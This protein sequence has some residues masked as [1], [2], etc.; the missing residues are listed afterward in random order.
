VS[1]FEKHDHWREKSLLVFGVSDVSRGTHLELYAS[2]S[3][4]AIARQVFSGKEGRIANCDLFLYRRLLMWPDSD[5]TSLS[6]VDDVL[7]ELRGKRWLFRG[8]SKQHRNLV[9]SI[10]RELQNKP[11]LQKLACERRSIDLFRSTARF[12]A[13]SGEQEA[14]QNDLTALMV[15]R[16]YGVPTRLLDWSLSPF[17][18]AYFAVSDLDDED[19][20][21]WCFDEP[22][23]EEIGRQQWAKWPE[24]TVSGDGRSFLADLTAFLVNP[25]DWFVCFFYSQY[26]GF[27]RQKAQT[28]AFSMTARFGVNHADAIA[29]LLQNNSKYHRYVVKR[30]LKRGLR[31]TLRKAHGIWRGSLYPDS[32]GAAETAKLEHFPRADKARVAP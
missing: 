28:G 14:L 32:A 22:L 3:S 26:A 31:D 19:G 4:H 24:T 12:F 15:L 27:H 18:A 10:D 20:E 2:S 23:Y 30:G 11:T 17:V 1:G 8:H 6:E 5:L 9:P 21:I 25:P 29:N 16:H 13:D 7:T